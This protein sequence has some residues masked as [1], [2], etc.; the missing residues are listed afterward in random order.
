MELCNCYGGR[1][2]CNDSGWISL[3]GICPRGPLCLGGERESKM[4]LCDVEIAWLKDSS[5]DW[6]CKI[7]FLGVRIWGSAR[8]NL[9]FKSLKFQ[10]KQE[11]EQQ[12]F[13][14]WS[15]EILLGSAHPFTCSSHLWPRVLLGIGKMGLIPSVGVLPVVLCLVAA[16]PV[17]VSSTWQQASCTCSIY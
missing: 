8:R 9:V 13:L 11:S 17:Y 2:K 6:S 1:W 3:P 15:L 7:E 14:H 16:G 10:M 5:H 12:S 4:S